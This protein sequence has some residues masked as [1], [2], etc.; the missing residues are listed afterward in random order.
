MLKKRNIETLKLIQ[1]CSNGFYIFQLC[2]KWMHMGVALNLGPPKLRII[3][4]ASF[5]WL[6]GTPPMGMCLTTKSHASWQ[7]MKTSRS[8]WGYLVTG[9]KSN[10]CRLPTTNSMGFSKSTPRLLRNPL[11]NHDSPLKK[12]MFGVNHIFA[13]RVFGNHIQVEAFW[14][15]LNPTFPSQGCPGQSLRLHLAEIFAA[16]RPFVLSFSFSF[17]FSLSFALSIFPFPWRRSAPTD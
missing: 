3:M 8:R 11:V 13:Q 5:W 2:S 7:M 17:S 10:G 16:L 4:I 1:Q 15:T 9:E 6:S 12:W 14:L